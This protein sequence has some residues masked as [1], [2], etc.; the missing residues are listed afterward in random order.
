VTSLGLE[1]KRTKDKLSDQCLDTSRTVVL[2]GISKAKATVTPVM[3]VTAMD[4]S[5]SSLASI[6][7]DP[8]ALLQE[9][10]SPFS[11]QKIVLD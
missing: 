4:I 2:D 11:E 5:A 8:A 1:T 3:L 9:F 7:S 6:I 10:S